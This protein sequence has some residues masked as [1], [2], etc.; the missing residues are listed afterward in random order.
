M[1]SLSGADLPG[2]KVRTFTARACIE[3]PSEV[4]CGLT[5]RRQCSAFSSMTLSR[6]T[7]TTTSTETASIL[8]GAKVEMVHGMP[9]ILPVNGLDASSPGG[10]IFPSH[11]CC[12]LDDDRP[13]WRPE[14]IRSRCA[15]RSARREVAA[16]DLLAGVRSTRGTLGEGTSL[17]KSKRQ[18]SENSRHSIAVSGPHTDNPIRRACQTTELPRFDFT[19]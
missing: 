8:S 9:R 11:G 4:V 6:S 18:V 19:W 1:I 3:P 10:S 7:S 14:M 5:D 12:R 17:A 16:G 15:H 13:R 2:A